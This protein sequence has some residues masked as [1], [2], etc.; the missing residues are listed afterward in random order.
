MSPEA[1]VGGGTGYRFAPEVN[2]QLVNS[3]KGHRIGFDRGERRAQ[4]TVALV[5]L[6]GGYG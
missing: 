3:G 5:A 1:N 4:L 2:M 6:P